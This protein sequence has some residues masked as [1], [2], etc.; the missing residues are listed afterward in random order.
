MAASKIACNATQLL[1]ARNGIALQ[2]I[3]DAGFDFNAISAEAVE[4]AE[5]N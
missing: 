2:A 3:F 1:G 5:K 4:E